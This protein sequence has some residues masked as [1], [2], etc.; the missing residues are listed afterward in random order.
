M[1]IADVGQEK[2]EEIDFA[3]NPGGV[4][5]NGGANYGWNCREGFSAYSTGCGSIGPFTDPV[6][7][8]PHEDPGD[9]SAHGCSI[10]GGYVARDASLGDLTGRY[11]YTDYC[12]G[13]IRSLLLPATSSG[14]ASGD[15]SEGLTVP[16]PTSFGQ[17]SCGRIYVASGQGTVYRLEGATP[18]AC[19]R[20]EAILA[21]LTKSASP[22]VHI[23]AR[24]RGLRLELTAW[25]SPCAGHARA[26][27]R[28]NRGGK[29]FAT[30][31]LSGRCVARFHP[32]V[33]R[34]ATFR[35][36]LLGGAEIRSPRLQVGPA[37]HWR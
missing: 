13:A 33:P 2:H 20:S 28:L 12:T 31:R 14:Q 6:F 11:L 18:A 9:G 22:R 5:S 23:R 7:D 30:K 36:L 16:E 34:Q 8:Y 26:R 21:V 37:R 27:L 29:P 10:I 17:D 24:R 15:R 19:P 32:R 3:A 4:V 25:V 1:V 35:A